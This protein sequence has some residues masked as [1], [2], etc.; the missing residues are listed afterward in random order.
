MTTREI[1]RTFKETQGADVPP[2]LISKV[3]DAV[4]EQV[5]EWQSRPLDAISRSFTW[6]ALWSRTDRI[7]GSSI[8]PSIWRWAGHKELPGLWLAENE[9]ARE[10]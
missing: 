6:T 7:S 2:T 9:G 3:R 4:I 8:K 1:V 10:L 5:V